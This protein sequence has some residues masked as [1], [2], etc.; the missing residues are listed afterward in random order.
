LNQ[1]LS[2]FKYT[3]FGLG[4]T[5][6]EHYNKIGKT[7][8]RELGNKGALCVHKYGEG[9]DNNSLEEDFTLWKETLWTSLQ[10]NLK[11]EIQLY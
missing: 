10:E 9:D 3:V 4:N 2:G 5:Q 7:V 11:E 8:N 6:Y 1:N